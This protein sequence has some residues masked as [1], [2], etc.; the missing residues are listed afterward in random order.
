[1]RLYSVYYISADSS[2]CFGFWHP[3]L[4]SR[5]T[6]ITASGTGQLQWIKY[7]ATIHCIWPVPEGVITVVRAP[8]DGCQHP[9]HVVLSADQFV[10]NPELGGLTSTKLCPGR[11]EW[12]E[13]LRP[14]GLELNLG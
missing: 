5:T 7:A 12:F 11:H 4:G 14:L 8:G 13:A 2:T 3:S 6:V 1:M 10:V 9:K